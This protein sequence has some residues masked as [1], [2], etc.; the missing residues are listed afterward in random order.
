MQ[1]LAFAWCVECQRMIPRAQWIEHDAHEMREAHPKGARKAAPIGSGSDAVPLRRWKTGIE[2][3]DR[4]LGGGI[5]PN[6]RILFTGDP[7]CGKSTIAL[8]A[9]WKLAQS[10]MRT[11][12]LTAEETREEVELRFRGMGLR[13]ESRLWLYATESWEA[14]RAAIT[15]HR[16]QVTVL[17]SLQEFQTKWAPG[18]PGDDR[19]VQ[20]ILKHTKSAV[21]DGPQRSM[22][23]IG[24]VNADG[25]A[26]GRMANVHKV[27]TWLHFSRDVQGRRVLSTR[28]NRHGASGEV[29]LFEF[30]ADGKPQTAKLIREVPDVSALLLADLLGRDGVVAYPVLPS[31]RLARAVVLPI[32]ASVSAPKGQSEPRVRSATGVPDRMLDDALDRLGDVG[33]K[34]LDRSVRLQAP[35]LGDAA[36][37]DHG[38]MLAV[39]AAMVAQ[40]EHLALGAV[41][42]F[43][44]LGASGRVLP[45]A[46]VEHRLAILARSRITL[47]FG[48]PRGSAELPAGM[49]Y[50]AVES[51][52]ELVEHLRARAAFARVQDAAAAAR[53]VAER[54]EAAEK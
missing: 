54:L 24:H 27:T 12:Y 46:Q 39:C 48:P 51:L 44:T 45:D 22:V 6:T 42:A 19:Q 52:D 5:V 29:A 47:A 25:H 41:G 17:D 26:Y 13:P 2:G 35:M 9:L 20:A 43:G 32:E 10:G 34:L 31:E 7:G 8:L 3:F 33:V 38:A 40:V 30:P 49:E 1:E 14:A 23:I 15:E 18:E 36:V 21:Q 28:K 11:L 50:V 4:C 16:P 37:T 53:T